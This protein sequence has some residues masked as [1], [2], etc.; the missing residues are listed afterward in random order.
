MVVLLLLTPLSWTK[1]IFSTKSQLKLQ[2][3]TDFDG[4]KAGYW[5][6]PELDVVVW[7]QGQDGSSELEFKE[8]DQGRARCWLN[9][10]IIPFY[11]SAKAPELQLWARASFQGLLLRME[12]SAP[13]KS[14]G[15]P[16]E[17]HFPSFPS[18]MFN[19]NLFQWTFKKVKSLLLKNDGC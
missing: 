1:P 5:H 13:S 14:L 15:A 18:R 9:F 19:T 11:L 8:Q 10:G 7:I 4:F 3:L 16:K 12:L 17:R 6:K 2:I